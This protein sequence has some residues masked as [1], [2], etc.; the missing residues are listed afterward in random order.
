MAVLR[1]KS[2]I[3]EMKLKDIA[4][5][6]NSRVQQTYCDASDVVRFKVEFKV[7][8]YS[9]RRCGRRVDMDGSN[10]L[11]ITGTSVLTSTSVGHQ[12]VYGNI[13]VL[14]RV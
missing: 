4:I 2:I 11:Y 12:F 14:Y 9:R 10:S 6:T 5:L 1:L 13:Y 7:R 8:R 3:L